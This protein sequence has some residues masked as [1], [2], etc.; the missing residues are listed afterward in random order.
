MKGKALLGKGQ[1]QCGSQVAL[2]TQDSLLMQLAG[3]AVQK[4]LPAPKFSALDLL[5][6]KQADTASLSPTFCS[7]T[8]AAK[9]GILGSIGDAAKQLGVG[10]GALG[11]LGGLGGI[12]GGST[13]APAAGTAAPASSGVGGVLG[14]VL[15]N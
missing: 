1:S 6:N 3:A 9:P 10:G 14:S 13:A 2:T 5:S 7:T 8:A 15:G 4:A 12:L 11:N